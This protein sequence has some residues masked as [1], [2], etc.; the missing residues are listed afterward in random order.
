MRARQ[1]FHVASLI[2]CGAL[3]APA[4]AQGPPD[5]RNPDL[6]EPR[7]PATKLSTM[8]SLAPPKGAAPSE[9]RDVVYD[10]IVKYTPSEIWNPTE[11]RPDK[12]KLRSY[13]GTGV[14][15]NTPFVGPQIEVYPGQTVRMTLHNELPVDP[16]CSVRGGSTNVPHCF[17]GTNLHTHGLWINPNGN[18]DNVLVSVNPGVNFQYEYNIPPDH[19]AGTYWYHSHRHG[20]TALQVS[21]GM[22][23]AL[24]V[25]GTR[26]PTPNGNGDLDTLLRPISGQPFTERVMVFQQIQYACRDKNGNIEFNKDK[27]GN[28]TT[29]KCN[30]NQVG[31][32]EDY[33]QFGPGTWPAVR[34]LHQH[35]RRRAWTAAGRR[36][37]QGRALADDPWR[38][39]RHHFPAI[40]QTP[41]IGA[42][43]GR[44]DH[45][46][47]EGLCRHQLHRH[48]GAVPSG[49]RRRPDHGGGPP[50]RGR[51][52]PAGLSLGCADRVSRA[53]RLLHPR[54][55]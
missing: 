36:G 33:D 46:H 32:V 28:D 31:G 23:G 1:L 40:P 15:P 5:I 13:V 51:G 8:F 50:H 14:N 54:Q 42:S 20:S 35:Q 18:G 4:A 19:P 47:G 29:Y 53:R 21:S 3:P 24:I 27:D 16:N 41:V 10:L 34:P 7:A 55:R 52:I 9:Q 30:A 45:G 12:V 22:A 39:P 6:L 49:G 43:A 38:R 11:N 25:R 48:A 44:I 37:R 17:N 26:P 2:A